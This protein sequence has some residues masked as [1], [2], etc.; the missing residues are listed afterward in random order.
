MIFD[1][2]EFSDQGI[3]VGS[4]SFDRERFNGFQPS[5]VDM[6]HIMSKEGGSIIFAKSDRLQIKVAGY[7]I[8]NRFS[9]VTPGVKITGNYKWTSVF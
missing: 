7:D 3:M 4:G 6:V 8:D 5:V 1:Q 2:S 9:F